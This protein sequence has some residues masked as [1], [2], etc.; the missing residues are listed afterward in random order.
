MRAAARQ[1]KAQ[2]DERGFVVTRSDAAE[3]LQLVEHPLDMIAILV[4]SEVASGR[5][6]P[7]SFERNDRQNAIHEKCCANVISV[8][9][10]V[11]EHGLGTIDR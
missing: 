9:A 5:F 7:I 6:F 1:R 2:N 4:S 10:F 8:V 11:C 3:L